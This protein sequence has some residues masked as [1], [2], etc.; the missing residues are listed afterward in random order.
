MLANPLGEL[1]EMGALGWL[2]YKFDRIVSRLS[3]GRIRLWLLC[4]YVQPVPS[5]SLLAP[6]QRSG[7]RVGVVPAGEIMARQFKRPEAAIDAR[8]R[9]G[10]ICI[11]GR[12]ESE[13][14]GFLW[15][16]FGPL[17]ERLFACDFEALP[18]HCTCWDYDL[19]IKPKYRLGRTFARLWDK[20]FQVLR[21]RGI[22]NTVSWIHYANRDSRRAHE[23]M[24]ATQAGWLV[25]LDVFGLKTALASS[26]PFLRIAGPGKR[27]YVPVQTARIKRKVA[28]GGQAV[29]GA[30]ATSSN[31]RG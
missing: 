29:G 21:E 9:Q 10:S 19:E 17:P 24:G 27:I 15:L 7:L 28:A 12:T 13:L 8:Y 2:G 6:G 11:A 1:K 30:R 18:Q 26:R 16:H 4:L 3:R 23:R 14:A 25:L 5:R 31:L 22:T 20:T